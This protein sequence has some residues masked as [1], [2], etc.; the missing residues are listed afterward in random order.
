MRGPALCL[1]KRTIKELQEPIR[2]SY[3]L[4]AALVQTLAPG[5]RVRSERCREL[6]GVHR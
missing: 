6:V 2:L 3:R 5:T 4:L 1:L